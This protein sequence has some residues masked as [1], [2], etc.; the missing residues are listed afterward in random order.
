MVLGALT[1]SDSQHIRRC[2]SL[3][4]LTVQKLFFFFFFADGMKTRARLRVF[5]QKQKNRLYLG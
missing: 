1:V 4:E 5:K 3:V 2:L